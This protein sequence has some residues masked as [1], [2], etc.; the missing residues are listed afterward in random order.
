MTIKTAQQLVEY[1]FSEPVRP[2][3]FNATP[4]FDAELREE[5]L[6]TYHAALSGELAY[7]A[8]TAEG[9][10]ALVIC[11]DQL[12]L[13]MFRGQAESFVGEAPARRVAA[14]A[15]ARGLDQALT[16]IQ[17]SFLYMPYMHSESLVDQQKVRVLFEQ[18]GLLDNLQWSKHHYDIVARFGRFPHRNAILGRESTAE[19]LAWLASDEAFTG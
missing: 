6:E 12:P 3:W 5:Y 17:K 18:A 19:E 8:D 1:W 14:T 2:L 13:N 4:E 10:L 15:I 9:A 11:L 7:W 16:A